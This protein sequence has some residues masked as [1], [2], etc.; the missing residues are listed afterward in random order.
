MQQGE[1]DVARAGEAE[2]TDDRNRGFTA[3]P[4][5]SCLS[6]TRSYCCHA[7]EAY[8][9]QGQSAG[10]LP[11]SSLGVIRPPLLRVTNA[12]GVQE[13]EG[14][15]EVPERRAGG[16]H[17]T[18]APLPQRATRRLGPCTGCN[19]GDNRRTGNATSAR[20]PCCEFALALGR[21]LQVS[22]RLA[23]LPVCARTAAQVA[24]VS[25]LI[26]LLHRPPRL[27]RRRSA[28]CPQARG[29]GPTIPPCPRSQGSWRQTIPAAAAAPRC[30]RRRPC[31]LPWAPSQGTSLGPLH[32]TLGSGRRCRL[33]LPLGWLPP[34][35]AC[36]RRRWARACAS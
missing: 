13:R 29:S 19:G 9:V 23:K 24:T 32:G 18:A 22:Q 34:R 21:L 27:Q 15:G 11:H 2:S 16:S 6:R 33:A 12:V 35:L 36:R 30:P 1:W 17:S 7:A 8:A 3:S 28:G 4:S 14:G 10:V 20:I 5:P 26:Q 31:V 25:Q